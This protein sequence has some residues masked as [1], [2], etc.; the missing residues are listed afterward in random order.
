[1]SLVRR[2]NGAPISHAE[3][4]EEH[5]DRDALVVYFYLQFERG[6][7]LPMIEHSEFT[8]IVP[9]KGDICFFAGE[10]IKVDKVEHFVTASEGS[11]LLNDAYTHLTKYKAGELKMEDLLPP[12]FRP[13]GLAIT[14][15]GSPVVPEVKRVVLAFVGIRH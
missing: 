2:V 4:G 7:H 15:S 9:A 13:T 3:V 12:A 11:N 5:M 8:N 6:S 1:L 10:E 14:L